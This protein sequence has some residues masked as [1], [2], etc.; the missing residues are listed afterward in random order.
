MD[1]VIQNALG[2]FLTRIMELKGTAPYAF[3]GAPNTQTLYSLHP[4]KWIRF[5]AVTS[6]PC[7]KSELSPLVTTAQLDS[8]SVVRR[9]E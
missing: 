6:T 2:A 8:E 9:A 5:F 1:I 3:I 7:T 4:N